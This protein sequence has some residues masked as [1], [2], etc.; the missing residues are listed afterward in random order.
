M[1]PIPERIHQIING[2]NGTK[3]SFL[4]ATLATEYLASTK[5]EIRHTIITMVRAGEIVEVEYRLPSHKNESLLLPK[6]TR[7]MGYTK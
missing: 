6:G 3:A 7:I 5:N 4:C 1:I 2:T